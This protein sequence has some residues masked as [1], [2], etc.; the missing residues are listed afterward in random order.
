MLAHTQRSKVL[1]LAT[2][3]VALALTGSLGLHGRASAHTPHPGLDFSIGVDTNGDTTPD[4]GTGVHQPAKC[5]A[6]RGAPLKALVY[7]NSFGALPTYSA[8]DI[9]VD[10][11]GVGSKNNPDAHS[12]PDCVY[13]AEHFEPGLVAW[14]CAVDVPPAPDSTYIGLIGTTSFN[15]TNNGTITLVHGEGST[16]LVSFPPIENHAEGE[17]LRETLTINC[18]ASVGGLAADIPVSGSSWLQWSFFALVGLV[19]FGLG[20]LGWTARRRRAR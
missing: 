7:L 2:F 1:V 9:I 8:F 11:T 6:S 3:A 16:K 14:G 12:W 17:G 4:C 10:Y 15:C 20:G 13:H 5:T 19:V 18:P